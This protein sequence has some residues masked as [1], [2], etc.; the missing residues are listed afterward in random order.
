MAVHGLPIV[1]D[2][3]FLHLELGAIPLAG[4]LLIES[5][6]ILPEDRSDMSS[7]GIRIRATIQDVPRVEAIW[8]KILAV[9]LILLGLTL[10]ASPYISYTTR[11]QIGHTPLKVK[12]EKTLHV[13]RPVAVAIIVTG[14][15]ALVLA[16]QKAQ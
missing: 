7:L 12:R 15:A 14:V 11:E 10:F 1:K 3:P 5:E 9:L 8:T 2:K 13:P 16:S 6:A 4:H